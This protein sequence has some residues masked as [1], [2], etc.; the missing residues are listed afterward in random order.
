M[1]TPHADYRAARN[2]TE[3]NTPHAMNVMRLMNPNIH[4]WLNLGLEL[5]YMGASQFQLQRLL[6]VAEP[7]SYLN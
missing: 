7:V 3:L 4:F 6:P 5:Y 1:R 2:A